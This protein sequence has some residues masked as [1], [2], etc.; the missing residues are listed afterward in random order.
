MHKLK[1]R[2][3]RDWK[4][5]CEGY[6]YNK[7]KIPQTI[8]INPK[9][10]YL[11]KGWK[12]FGDWL[13]TGN[14]SPYRKLR[15]FND[16]KK[17]AIKNNISTSSEWKKT[18]REM[19]KAFPSDIPRSPDLVYKGAGWKGWP[20]FLCSKKISPNRKVC[21]FVKTKRFAKK[22]NIRTSTQWREFFKKIKNTEYAE[23]PRTLS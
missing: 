17:W 13:G 18:L 4:K 22:H 5:A 20:Q 19:G 1:L 14:L 12:G 9:P 16:A 23:I 6:K 8:P 21:S 11:S 7:A 15:S 2:S 3:T 10:I